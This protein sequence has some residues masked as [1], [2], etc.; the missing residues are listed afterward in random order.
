MARVRIHQ[1]SGL[2]LKPVDIKVSIPDIPGLM[3]C[4][5]G[6]SGCLPPFGVFLQGTNFTL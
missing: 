2:I 5:R 6:V 1:V 3:L 4:F